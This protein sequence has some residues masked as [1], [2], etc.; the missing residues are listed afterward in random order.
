MGAFEALQD[1]DPKQVGPFRLV[2]RLG[3]GGMGR[4]YLGHSKGGRDVAVKVVRPE[5]GEDR[6]FLERFA[7]EMETK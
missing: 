1:E 4:V 2:A 6:R 7:R 3:A 5:L